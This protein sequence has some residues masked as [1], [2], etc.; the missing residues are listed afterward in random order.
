[1]FSLM[2]LKLKRTSD[3]ES[4]KAV[5]SRPESN[6]RNTSYLLVVLYSRY[7]GGADF[8]ERKGGKGRIGRLDPVPAGGVM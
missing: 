1:M 2:K 6:Y 4:I 3:S 8:T 7:L 5:L